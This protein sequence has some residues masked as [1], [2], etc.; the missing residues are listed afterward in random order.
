[1]EFDQNQLIQ[2]SLSLKE[3]LN[4]DNYN[5]ELDD[6]FLLQII[7]AIFQ[8]NRRGYQE[9]FQK[10]LKGS[11]IHLSK[12][13][14]VAESDYLVYR[15]GI[16][17]R[18]SES[19][20]DYRKR[21]RKENHELLEAILNNNQKEFNYFYEDEF[22]KVARLIL[23]NNGTLENAKDIFQ[24]ALVIVIE[25][26]LHQK[27]DLTC[28]LGTYIYSVCRYTWLN[29]LKKR[30]ITIRLEDSYS[31][32]EKIEI[33]SLDDSDN[34]M[35]NV[36][37]VVSQLGNPCK[38]LLEL[39]YYHNYSWKQ[40]ADELGYASPASARN[41]KYKCLERIRELVNSQ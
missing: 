7:S 20:E 28:S 29:Y 5:E 17:F 26:V 34:A 18:I 37:T 11:M 22:P 41:Q 14:Y 24:D 13:G 4:P 10:L 30:K 19:D 31:I 39:F 8:N 33:L 15:R 16:M 12:I 38:K 9:K 3:W 32:N 23:N 1:M 35:D 36:T 6:T 40:I 27:I 21:I 25:N 2:N